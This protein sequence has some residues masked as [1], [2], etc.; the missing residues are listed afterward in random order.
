M[1]GPLASAGDVLLM[2]AWPAVVCCVSGASEAGSCRFTEPVME[3][4]R[5]RRPVGYIQLELK[6]AFLSY[7][8]L[9]CW[10]GI[11]FP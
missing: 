10:F 6:V 1:Q 9:R 3:P 7:I 8:L 5:F 11:A 4:K 2:V